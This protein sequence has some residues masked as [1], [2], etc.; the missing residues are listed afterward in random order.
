MAFRGAIHKIMLARKVSP[1]TYRTSLHLI[2]AEAGQKGSEF[3]REISVNLESDADFDE[4]WSSPD[5]RSSP[6][7]V[8]TVNLSRIGRADK[9]AL[10]KHARA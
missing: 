6:L 9:R 1:R 10:G 3:G 7:T 8:P 4:R 5:H 2:R